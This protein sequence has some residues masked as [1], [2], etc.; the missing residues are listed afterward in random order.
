[1]THTKNTPNRI[2]NHLG[3]PLDFGGGQDDLQDDNFGDGASQ[4]PRNN[5]WWT[6]S[7]EGNA[8][9]FGGPH[10]NAFPWTGI[11]YTYDWYYQNFGT[12]QDWGEYWQMDGNNDDYTYGQGLAE[13]VMLQSS[14]TTDPINFEITN[15]Q[16]TYQYMGG[17]N[18]PW[19]ITTP[20]PTTLTIFGMAC[21]A[22][23]GMHRRRRR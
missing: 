10:P 21:L 13:Y 3:I 1:M 19:A 6:A 22:G 5:D 16:T 23:L 14:S 18:G 9:Q 12:G 15:V 8:R 20:E 17:T 2:S 7:Y 11:G 4:D